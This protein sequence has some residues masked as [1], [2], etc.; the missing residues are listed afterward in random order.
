MYAQQVLMYFWRVTNKS[1]NCWQRQLWK[2][3]HSNLYAVHFFISESFGM[4]KL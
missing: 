4:A 2:L 1:P 3:F